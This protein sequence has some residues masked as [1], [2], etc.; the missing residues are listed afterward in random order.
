[1][2]HEQGHILG[3]DHDDASFEGVMNDAFTVGERVL[4]ELGEAL[5]AT[6]GPVTGIEA[7]HFR[8]G[9]ISWKLDTSESTNRSFN[10]FV[11]QS[12]RRT[13]FLLGLSD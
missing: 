10:F 4:P 9:T 6:P 2:L 13:A 8:F 11:E 12:W 1:M 7:S 3:L 5:G